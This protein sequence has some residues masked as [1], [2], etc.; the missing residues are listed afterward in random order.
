MPNKSNASLAS[1]GAALV[2]PAATAG[3]AAAAADFVPWNPDR[4]KSRILKFTKSDSSIYPSYSNLTL[5]YRVIC[6]QRY[7]RC[8]REQQQQII[9][10]IRMHEELQPQ[11][12]SGVRLH[13]EF[14]DPILKKVSTRDRITLTIPEER[15]LEY[16]LKT[17]PKD[18]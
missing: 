7:Q 11:A 8:I 5:P 6:R 9:K 15:R 16:I 1:T 14:C 3:A 17:D 13:R 10:E 2:E 18:L 4:V 12:L